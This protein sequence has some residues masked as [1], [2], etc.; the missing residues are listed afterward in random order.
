MGQISPRSTVAGLFWSA[1][2]M[3]SQV[4]AVNASENREYA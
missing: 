2:R 3:K 1:Q 4:S